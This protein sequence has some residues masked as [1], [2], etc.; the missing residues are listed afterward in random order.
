MINNGTERKK[1]KRDREERRRE[2]P[3]YLYS[4][5]PSD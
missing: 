4:A 1:R 3:T 2:I 5:L